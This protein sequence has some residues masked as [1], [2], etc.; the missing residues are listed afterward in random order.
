MSGRD[1]R[2]VRAIGSGRRHRR[3]V[4]GRVGAWAAVA[5]V[6]LGW[7]FLP[8]TSRA[9]TTDEAEVTTVTG[10]ET[11]E[12]ALMVAAI[13][14]LMSGGTSTA[15]IDDRSEGS[16]AVRREFIDGDLDFIVTGVPFSSAETQELRDASRQV[17]SAPVQAVGLAMFGFAPALPV[18]PGRCAPTDEVEDP[19]C[20]FFDATRYEGAVRLTPEVLADL[21]Y[22]RSN[23]WTLPEL[24][25]SLE[26]PAD[27]SFFLPPISGPR[28][29]VR[30][31]ADASNLFLDRYLAATAAE[32]RRGVLSAIPGV[33]PDA[34]PSETWPNPVTPSRSSQDN[35]VAQIAE[36]LDPGASQKSEGG[37]IG[38]ASV[39]AVSGAFQLNELRPDA[40][41]TGLFR[42]QL[43]NAA[44]EWVAPTTESITAAVAA[45][46]G[47]AM[48][49]SVDPV[50]GAYPVTWVNRLHA[51]ATGLTAEEANVVATMIRVQVTV[52]QG[53][54]AVLLGD[55]RLPQAQ[56]REAL[57]AADELVRS[58]C[59]AAKGTV[60][61]ARGLGP[62]VPAA[63][64]GGISEV[65]L[66]RGA[67]SA[68]GGGDDPAPDGVGEEFVVG[69][70]D[71]GV[72]EDY[73]VFDDDGY[74]DDFGVGTEAL[75]A[76]ESGGAAD[77]ASSSAAATA[78][79][80]AAR[81]LMPL[82][83]PGA[84]LSPLDRAMTLALG[85]GA[86]L[87]GRRAWL[88]RRAAV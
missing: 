8:G 3:S 69:F 22:E 11:G 77:T 68:G 32:T 80:V 27:G 38:A 37:S 18:F 49:G 62:Y 12:A 57:S 39:A 58:N 43:R 33:D 53:D 6:V 55:G 45:A 84:S 23:I 35:V 50:P 72:Y 83:L 47:G 79:R 29:L 7:V 15:A 87:L 75:G 9:Q 86:F 52:G 61:T 10:V 44:G 56:V 20:T 28:P 71:F 88:R 82:P 46:G 31:D 73:G 54:P 66:C 25:S 81:G 65:T 24:A 40:E 74:F 51:P 78:A 64:T 4:I 48:G 2:G 41:R 13:A 17:I 42:V 76:V 30:N 5:A 63:T 60:V 70:D 59:A 16:A 34:A 14:Q 21:Y 36:G 1:P 19:G 26:L 85:A 67:S